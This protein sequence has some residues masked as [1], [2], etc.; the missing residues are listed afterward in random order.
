MSLDDG[1]FLMNAARYDALI[2]S[3]QYTH[4]QLTQMRLIRVHQDF[5][6]IALAVHVPTFGPLG[7]P[8]EPTIRSR[9]QARDVSELSIDVYMPLLL[10][11]F[12]NMSITDLRILAAT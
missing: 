6:V 5:R 7:Y 12:R 10:D 2:H 4:K 11:Y 1:R 9:F 8:L 3:G